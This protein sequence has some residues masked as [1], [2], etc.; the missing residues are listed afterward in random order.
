MT[1]EQ[2]Q[3]K[4]NDL[5]LDF[6]AKVLTL[7]RDSDRDFDRPECESICDF[8]G[9]DYRTI[10]EDDKFNTL[11]SDIRMG[12]LNFEFENGKLVEVLVE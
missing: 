1:D 11:K 9:V 6:S 8:L 7:L 2:L 5:R 3:E 10:R 12:R 4:V